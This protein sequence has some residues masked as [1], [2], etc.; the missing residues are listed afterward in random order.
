MKKSFIFAHSQ[1]II[2]RA[3]SE[4]RYRALDNVQYVLVGDGQCSNDSVLVAR[5]QKYNVEQYDNACAYSGWIML[6]KN[7][8]I[9][10]DDFVYLFEYDTIVSESVGLIQDE[11][12]GFF[13]L[14]SSHYMFFDWQ[15]ELKE[16]VHKIINGIWH[17]ADSLFKLQYVPMTS[18]MAMKGKWLKVIAMELENA[19]SIIGDSPFLGHILERLVV[20]IL[21]KYNIPF[22]LYLNAVQHQ[23]AC[24][25]G[26]LKGY[27]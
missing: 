21:W 22:R 11:V 8:Y 2:E 24:S 17:D 7:N 14:P 25:H 3:I 6:A 16:G 23:M 18:N 27:T 4:D 19:L 13:A 20:F 1:E 12:V 10:N 15:P 5:D 9:D 26:Q